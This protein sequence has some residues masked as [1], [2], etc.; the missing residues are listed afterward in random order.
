VQNYAWIEGTIRWRSSEK[1]TP[2]ARY[3]G[4]PYDVQAHYSKKRFC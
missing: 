3:I 2:A 1:I 4:S